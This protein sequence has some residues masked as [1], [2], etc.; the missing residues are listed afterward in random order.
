[1]PCALLGNDPETTSMTTTPWRSLLTAARWCARAYGLY[2]TYQLVRGTATAY[3]DVARAQRRF[4][5]LY[6]GRGGQ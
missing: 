1:M 6:F 5:K 2:S 4:R 3:N